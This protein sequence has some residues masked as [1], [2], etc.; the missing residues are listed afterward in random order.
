[1]HHI[2]WDR[3]GFERVMRAPIQP[4]INRTGQ[5][6]YNMAWEKILHH[7]R[8]GIIDGKL[9]HASAVV[10]PWRM[11]WS[12]LFDAR[13]TFRLYHHYYRLS[14][15]C[16]LDIACW[17]ELFT[18]W[19]GMSFFECSGWEPDPDIH[20][21]SDASL[22]WY[23]IEIWSSAYED[24]YRSVSIAFVNKLLNLVIPLNI[25]LYLT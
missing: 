25:Y 19:N 6:Y 1:M 22:F 14:L 10:R 11:F 23:G 21:S 13:R 12:R 18:H 8:A 7:T 16:K 2:L 9:Q 3:V 15:E 17:N 5:S 20:I 24:N 4:Q